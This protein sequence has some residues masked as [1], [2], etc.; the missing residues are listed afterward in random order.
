MMYEERKKGGV[1]DLEELVVK[2]PYPD[3][4]IPEKT[5]T[6]LIWERHGQWEHQ[7]AV[8]RFNFF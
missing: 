3:I 2:S 8:V 1:G 7:I 4:E 5:F 6:Q